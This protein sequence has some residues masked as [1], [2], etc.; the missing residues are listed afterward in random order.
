MENIVDAC[1]SLVFIKENVERMDS[2]EGGLF[3]NF[4]GMLTDSRWFISFSRHEYFRR[5]FCDYIG[6][7]VERGKIPNDEALLEKLSTNVSYNNAVADFDAT[8]VVSK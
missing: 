5:L 6:D 1:K 2:V 7:L 8:D 3:M 4:V